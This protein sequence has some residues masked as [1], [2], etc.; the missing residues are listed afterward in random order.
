MHP[1]HWPTGRESCPLP[2]DL[3]NQVVEELDRL[4]SRQLSALL[5]HPQVQRLEAA[6]RG[7]KL[8]VDRLDFRRNIRLSVLPLAK[9]QLGP[10]LYHQMLMATFS[11]D[12]INTGRLR[13]D[14]T[15]HRSLDHRRLRRC[16]FTERIGDVNFAADPAPR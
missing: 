4:L 1:R 3:A 9:D 5:H 7:L 14:L 12:P 13:S 10:A 2:A 16:R 8:L 11:G 15:R 6:W